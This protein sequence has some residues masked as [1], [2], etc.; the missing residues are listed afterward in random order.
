MRLRAILPML[1]AVIRPLVLLHSADD[2]DAGAAAVCPYLFTVGINAVAYT[3]V[4]VN[5][6]AAVV[7][8]AAA[9]GY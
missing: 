2:W 7:V 6:W 9:V 3:G 4:L 5:G 1:G 8:V